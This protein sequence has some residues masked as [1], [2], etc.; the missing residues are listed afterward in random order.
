MKLQRSLDTL[1]PITL[2]LLCLIVQN[3]AHA[4]TKEQKSSPSKVAVAAPATQLAVPNAMSTDTNT[5]RAALAAR[6]DVEPQVNGS[7][8]DFPS[9][10]TGK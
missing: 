3:T 10:G 6:R 1:T 7:V 2:A 9:T 5:D 4:E 8:R